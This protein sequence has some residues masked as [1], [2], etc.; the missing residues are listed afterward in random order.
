MS[1]PLRHSTSRPKQ[2]PSEPLLKNPFHCIE[3]ITVGPL[4]RVYAL[5]YRRKRPENTVEGQHE[6]SN[7]I[8]LTSSKCLFHKPHR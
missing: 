2:L 3:I 8:L 6:N 5:E 4:K 7:I 1:E